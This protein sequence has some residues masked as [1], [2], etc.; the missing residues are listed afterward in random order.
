[1]RGYTRR[2]ALRILPAYWLAL[3][4]LSIWPGTPGDVLGG[5]WWKFYGLVHIYGMGTL[6]Q[7]L[8]VTWSL[9]VELSFYALLPLI[10][11]L[12]ARLAGALRA[13]WWRAELAAITVFGIVGIALC[14]PL[15][16]R[17]WPAWTAT[18]LALTSAWFAMGMGLAVLSV[19]A[20]SGGAAQRVQ[21][22][23]AHRGGLLWLAAL[24]VFLASARLM[25]LMGQWP[26]IDPAV[27]VW[28]LAIG[29][30]GERALK[31]L[32]AGLLLAPVVA[33][34][35]GVVRAVTTWRPL[36]LLGLISYG[37]FVWHFVVAGWIS[38]RGVG[39]ADGPE[40]TS[41]L[42]LAILTFVVSVAVATVSYRF[43]ELPLLRRKEPRG[44]GRHRAV[45]AELS[46]E[47]SRP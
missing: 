44:A 16:L 38:G 31:G 9:C 19:A 3:T 46:P 13:V 39:V 45:A 23:V 24:I 5:D 43:V 25:W 30:A 41:F 11:W 37:V 36:M 27:H 18:T 12:V 35:G 15:F 22:W 6:T 1:M 17:A 26:A 20:E 7:G 34:A 8:G 2:R 14:F 4:V 29:Y 32:A 40:V 10:A 42:P 47:P 33:G 21:A 28:P